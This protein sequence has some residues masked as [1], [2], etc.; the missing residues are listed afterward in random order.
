[1]EDLNNGRPLNWH[2]VLGSYAPP[3][4]TVAIFGEV[5]YHLS[6]FQTSR[7]AQRLSYML[8]HTTQRHTAVKQV[9]FLFKSS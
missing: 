3:L 5:Y 2:N 6:E 7:S 9:M 8:N 4:S 1:M